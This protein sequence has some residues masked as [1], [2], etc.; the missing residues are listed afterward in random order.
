MFVYEKQMNLTHLCSDEMQ[1]SE[2]FLQ[3]LQGSNCSL[4][5]TATVSRFRVVVKIL[6]VMNNFTTRKKNR[7]F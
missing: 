6:D 2:E 4:W 1:A 5:R 3:Q 7:K